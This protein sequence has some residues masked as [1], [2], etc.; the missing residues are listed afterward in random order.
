MRTRVRIGGS[1]I[2]LLTAMFAWSP[3]SAQTGVI[4]VEVHEAEAW[5]K[6]IDACFG[7]WCNEQDFVAQVAFP[8]Y[9][10]WQ[11]TA[12][13]GNRDHVS[14]SPPFVASGTVSKLQRYHDLRVELRDKDDTSGDD[15]FDISPLPHMELQ[16]HFDACSQTWEEIGLPKV[17]GPGRAYPPFGTFYA[18][19]G[20]EFDGRVV[21]D[22][23]TEGR[24]PFTTD[25]IA[26]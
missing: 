5:A 19:Q 20:H 7:P 2:L 9:L 21:I 4:Q 10:I 1:L 14:W 23:H 13:V 26:I 11:R 25:D 16:V 18:N 3:L 6:G 15:R 24:I 8:P 17:Y 22:V 12:E